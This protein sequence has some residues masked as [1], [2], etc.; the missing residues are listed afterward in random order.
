MSLP[1]VVL[2]CWG[3]PC[4]GEGWLHSD[5]GGDGVLPSPSSQPCSASP[6]GCNCD[7]RGTLGGAA[8]CQLVSLRAEVPGAMGTEC[9]DPPRPGPSFSLGL[10]GNGQCFCKPHV[11]GQTCA[12][13]KDG[14]FGLDQA[15]Y[16]GCR[17]KAHCLAL[18]PHPGEAEAQ[19]GTHGT[20]ASQGLGVTW[21]S[22]S[23]SGYLARPV[24]V[25]RGC[26]FNPFFSLHPVPWQA[27]LTNPRALA[28][29]PD[30]LLSRAPGSS[31]WQ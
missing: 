14:F 1:G 30:P 9:R 29:N 16:F 25:W 13:C 17:S 4:G 24:L 18:G 2:G 8:Q 23:H 19:G 5:Q 21:H 28:L 31:W 20:R 15:D 22:L 6:P 3:R 10:Q 7:P 12:A 27:S 26:R 11:C